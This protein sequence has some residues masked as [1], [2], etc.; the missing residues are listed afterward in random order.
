MGGTFSPPHYGHLRLAEVSKEIFLFK[1]IIFLP[2]F[3]PPHKN[4]DE[5][6]FSPEDRLK[7]VELSIE[8]NPY[9]ELSDYEIK[10]GGV[11]YTIDTLRHFRNMYEGK[12]LFF[13][14]GSDQLFLI[15]SWKEWEKLI[16]EFFFVFAVRPGHSIEEVKAFLNS[17]GLNYKIFT[18]KDKC[19]DNE[20]L[21]HAVYILDV[22]TLIDVSSTYINS[23]LKRGVSIKY[24][25][26]ESVEKYILEKINYRR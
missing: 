25:L 6:L 26:K 3:T 2:A 14:A 22:K 8:G 16:E 7:M 11:S 18:E 17:N 20:L 9:F 5:I 21:E 23:L 10:K 1:K 13:I 19:L 24:L 12:D 15:K 4:E